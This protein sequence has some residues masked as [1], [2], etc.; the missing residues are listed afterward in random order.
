M[1]DRIGDWQ[2]RTSNKLFFRGCIR[3]PFRLQMDC[4]QLAPTP[5]E[6]IECILIFRWKLCTIPKCHTRWRTWPDIKSCW[7]TVCI[8]RRSL[9]CTIPPAN[10]STTCHMVNSCRTIP[11]SIKV[12]LHI[13]VIGEEFTIMIERCIKNIPK[14]I[15]ID[16]KIFPIS[17][18]FVDDATRRKNT[19]I[20]TTAIRKTWQE[21]IFSP[22]FWH[23]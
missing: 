5:I 4:I 7:Q 9:S 1:D 21:V 10:L 8:K 20:M 6:C 17:I 23:L 2:W 15:C 3:G 19:T 13:C 12:V 14:T 22:D 11:R 16:F 18:N